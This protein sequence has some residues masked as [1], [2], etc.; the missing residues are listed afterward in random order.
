M[1]ETTWM[2]TRIQGNLIEDSGECWRNFRGT[3]KNIP[4][5]DSKDTGEGSRRFRGMVKKIP[6]N[7]QKDSGEV[8]DYSF[9]F[10]F[11]Y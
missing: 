7:V 5:N 11:S 6:G 4:G 8:E 3:F 10:S 2:F 9:L 1:R